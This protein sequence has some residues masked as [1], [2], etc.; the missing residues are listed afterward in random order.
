MSVQ[1]RMLGIAVALMVAGGLIVLGAFAAVGFDVT[2]IGTRRYQT[3]SITVTEEFTALSIDVSTAQVTLAP[4]ADGVCRIE[5]CHEEKVAVTA[6]VRDGVLT[7][8]ERDERRW[9]EHIGI[10]FGDREAVTV[11]LPA[12]AYRALSVTVDTG[13]VMIPQQVE[14]EDITVH[15]ATGDVACEARL[16][17]AVSLT[18][19]TGDVTVTG[20]QSE[21]LT[22]SVNT[23][24]VL[25][26]DVVAGKL[27]VT[28][29]TGDVRLQNSDGDTVCIQTATG[30]VSGTLRTE[31]VFIVDTAT[32][33]VRVP[34]SDRGGR[35]EITTSTGDVTLAFA[36]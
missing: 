15:T 1:K 31:K 20:L 36:T 4:A 13:D 23:G 24:D 16:A 22:V 12:R 8:C 30:D 28:T 18:T 7:L 14:F 5:W 9:Y 29:D 33:D 34:Q 10:S 27:S 17:R 2:A 26:T 21:R 6:C 25:L 32:G 11:Y 19:S 3:E 35:C